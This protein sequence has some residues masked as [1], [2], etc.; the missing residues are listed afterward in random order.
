MLVV[1]FFA[2]RRRHTSCALVTGVQTCALPISD[3]LEA[4]VKARTCGRG[5]D[6]IYDAVGRDSFSHSLRALANCGHL[7]SYGQASG[8]IGSWDV[9]S[10][11]SNSA[12]LSRPNYGHYTDTPERVAAITERLFKALADGVVTP[13]VGQRFPLEIGRA[14]GRERVCQYV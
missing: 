13:E 1:L 7:V 12:T 14:S 10:L 8:P 5:A 3:S 11:Q 6:G 2:S 4:Q 9:G